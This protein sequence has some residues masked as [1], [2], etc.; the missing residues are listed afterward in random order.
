[1]YKLKLSTFIKI[2]LIFYT[3]LLFRDLENLLSR[4][5][6]LISS[7]VII[8]KDA[9]IKQKVENIIDIKR[10]DKYLKIRVQ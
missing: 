8:K 3:A 5:N 10:I 4:Q 7:L 1:M 6:Y 9:D 2:Y